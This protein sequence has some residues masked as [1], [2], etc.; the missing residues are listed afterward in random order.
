MKLD[1]FGPKN[2]AGW[3]YDHHKLDM[4]LKKTFTAVV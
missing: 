1:R 3:E 2:P 4:T